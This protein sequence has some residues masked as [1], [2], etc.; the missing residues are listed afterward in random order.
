M[1][2]SLVDALRHK[3]TMIAMF[4]SWR[5]GDGGG[6]WHLFSL[7]EGLEGRLDPNNVIVY[8]R[9][10]RN[11]TLVLS[12]VKLD[13]L[14]DFDWGTETILH[15]DV[16]ERF[17]EPLF[18]DEGVS[19]DDTVSHTFSKTKSLLQAAKVGVE[20]ALKEYAEVGGAE[21]GGKAGAEA[22][23]KV[24]AEYSRQ[25]GGSETESDSISRHISITG[26]WKGHYEAVRSLDKERRTITADP[27]FEANVELKSGG[28]TIA[29]WTSFAEFISTAQGRAPSDR[30]LYHEFIS[31]PLDDE[32]VRA[33]D[34]YRPKKVEFT[35]D[36]DNV[37]EQRITVKKGE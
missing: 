31:D 32:E 24:S 36:Y 17:V 23:E 12:N 15:K 33:I 14:A 6:E 16:Q 35:V 37:Q 26:P 28:Q 18:I 7:A 3:A 25:W 11:A 29:S 13:D 21:M 27:K 20:A 2:T 30:S 1:A 4:S 22:T 10:G 9:P 5:M 19:Y 34:A 8:A